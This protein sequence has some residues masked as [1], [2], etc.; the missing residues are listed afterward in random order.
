MRAAERAANSLLGGRG[1][2]DWTVGDLA[3]AKEEVKRL[4]ANAYRSDAMIFN[5]RGDVV[6]YG[7][8]FDRLADRAE[9]LAK[10]LSNDV[11]LIDRE[12]ERNFSA[13]RRMARRISANDEERREFDMIYRGEKMLEGRGKSGDASEW[14][15]QMAGMG[16]ISHETAAMGNNVNIMDAINNELN[17]EKNRIYTPISYYGSDSAKDY[18]SDI[19]MGLLEGYKPVARGANRRRKG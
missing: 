5:K 15:R 8:G 17:A 6:D 4:Y 10:K 3:F 2:S 1:S 19:F 7:R 9:A 14:A 12:A 11:L 16:L 13:M 18:E